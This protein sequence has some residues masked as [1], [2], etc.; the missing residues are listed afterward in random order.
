MKAIMEKCSYAC[1]IDAMYNNQNTKY[2]P[3]S[4]LSLWGLVICMSWFYFWI[5]LDSLWKDISSQ[6]FLFLV[7]EVR[8]WKLYFKLILRAVWTPSAFPGNPDLSV[9]VHYI[10]TQ[11]VFPCFGLSVFLSL[12][13]VSRFHRAM[14]LSIILSSS[15]TGP[16]NTLLL[17]PAVLHPA[18]PHVIKHVCWDTRSLS[19]SQTHC[20][21]DISSLQPSWSVFQ[22]EEDEQIC[23]FLSVTSRVSQK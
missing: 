13:L 17:T 19:L 8:K 12:S 14:C 9:L 15:A 5:Y 23:C 2:L 1:K 3:R 6:L 4:G 16:K 20:T 18:H 22:L 21:D 10:D 7:H 11:S